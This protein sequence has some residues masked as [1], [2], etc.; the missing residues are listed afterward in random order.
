MIRPGDEEMMAR[1]AHFY[2]EEMMTQEAIAHRLH[3]TRWKVGRL[4]KDARSSG[5]VTISI[6]HGFLRL[7]ELESALCSRFALDDAVVVVSPEATEADALASVGM[8]AAKY[9]TGLNPQPGLIGTSW[10]RTMTAVAHAIP[11]DWTT[12]VHVVQLNGA[13]TLGSAEGALH[14]PAQRIAVAGN[15][16]YTLLPVPAIVDQESVRAGL[17]KDSTIKQILTI[18]RNAPVAIFGLGS[19]SERSVLVESGYLTKQ[20]VTQ[21]KKS[22][23]VGDVLGRF[24]SADGGI[25]DPSLNNRTLGITL[26]ELREKPVRIA[27]AQGSH[28]TSIARGALTAGLVSTLVIDEQLARGLVDAT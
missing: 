28:K 4:L 17:E 14:D 3:L 6:K 2:Y 8:A 20:E 16:R 24:I 5:V 9:L 19:L 11:E 12:G 27:V 18:G 25:V 21:L 1:V 13:L 15:G 10:G 23:A 7:A 26:D 22:D